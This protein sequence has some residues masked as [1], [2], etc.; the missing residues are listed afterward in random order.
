MC[1]VCLVDGALGNPDGI[2]QMTITKPEGVKTAYLQVRGIHAERPGQYRIW[3]EGEDRGEWLQTDSLA[4]IATFYG[5]TV[6]WRVKPPMIQSWLLG[7]R[8]KPTVQEILD[9]RRPRRERPNG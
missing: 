3:L 1:D 8:G 2:I 5:F 4:S 9:A 7:K 6:K